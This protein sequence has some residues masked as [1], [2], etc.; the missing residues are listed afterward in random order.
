MNNYNVKTQRRPA[1]A[2]SKKLRENSQVVTSSGSGS[3]IVDERSSGHTHTN[4]G[5]LD[6]LKIDEDRY[7]YEHSKL[8]DAQEASDNK[9]KSGYADEAKHSET[10]DLALQAENADK[11]DD[12]DSSQFL[13]K[14]I[15]DTATE[16]ITFQKGIIAK[17]TSTSVDNGIV[18]QQSNS[19][20]DI[21][22]IENS[23]DN[24]VLLYS[25]LSDVEYN[26]IQNHL[27]NT[28][29][30]VSDGSYINKLF[31]GEIQILLNGNIPITNDKFTYK[32]PLKLS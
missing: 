31:L 21:S 10:A 27:S 25:V 28:L 29:Y 6:S 5:L 32:I 20:V 8:Q 15:E 1:L 30:C 7:L 19:D 14:D 13:R 23:N 9:I 2:R 22:I 17:S 12:L 4:K 18:E 3:V 24:K 26:A 11:L 16:K